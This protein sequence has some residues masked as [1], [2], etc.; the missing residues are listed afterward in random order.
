MMSLED[1]LFNSLT[2]EHHEQ[3]VK[4]RT[5]QDMSHIVGYQNWLT[6]HKELMELKNKNQADTWEKSE[7][8]PANYPDWD[9]LDDTT[10]AQRIKQGEQDYW[11]DSEAL[12]TKISDLEHL[13]ANPNDFEKS[14]DDSEPT[15]YWTTDD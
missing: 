5:E 14:D 13:L 1:Y 7:H 4:V 12:E 2:K 10:K 15:E 6:A 3:Y 11:A 8:N 9:S